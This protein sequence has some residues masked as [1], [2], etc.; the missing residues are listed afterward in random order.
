MSST[1]VKSKELLSWNKSEEDLPYLQSSSVCPVT[2]KNKMLFYEIEME[3][4]TKF[5]SLEEILVYIY[6]KLYGKFRVTG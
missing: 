4:R 6:Q 5:V 1:V 3:E 2:V